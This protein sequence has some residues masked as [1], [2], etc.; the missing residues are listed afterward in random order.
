MEPADLLGRYDASGRLRYTGRTATTALA[1]AVTPAGAST[2]GRGV[3]SPPG[4]TAATSWTS[5]SPTP[6]LVAEQPGVRA[7]QS[8][9]ERAVR[10]STRS[11]IDVSMGRPVLE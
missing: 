7:C 11:R 2:R 3:R 8:R 9:L 10:S 6:Q 1:D 5:R 4:A